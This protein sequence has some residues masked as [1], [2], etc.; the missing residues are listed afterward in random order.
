MQLKLEAADVGDHIGVVA[1]ALDLGID[2]GP[3]TLPYEFDA[4]VDGS[5]GNT[6]VNGRLDQL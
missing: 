2:P 5:L 1:I 4:I 6:G 3:G